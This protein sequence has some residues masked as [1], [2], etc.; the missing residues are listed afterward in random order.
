MHAMGIATAAMCALAGGAVWCLLSLYLRSE[1]ALTNDREDMR[2]DATIAV[3][4]ALDAGTAVWL[5]RAMRDGR[6]LRN[7]HARLRV[8]VVVAVPTHGSQSAVPAQHHRR[9]TGEL[10]EYPS[11]PRDGRRAGELEGREK[12]DGKS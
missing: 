2:V 11:L 3:D 6:A 4:Y 7:Q 10:L 1:L 9:R 5:P 12:R 8:R